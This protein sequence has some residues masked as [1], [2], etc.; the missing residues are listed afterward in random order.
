ME[1]IEL[2]FTTAPLKAVQVVESAPT[3]SVEKPSTE[4]TSEPQ[5]L[6]VS[7][8]N[9]LIRENL[10]SK[11]SLIWLRGEISNFKAHSSG[12]HYFSL[13]DSK[14]QINAIMFRAFNQRLKFRPQD[15]MEVVVR[16]KITVYEPRGNYQMF[17]ELMEPMGAGAL[18]MAFEQ[19]KKKL[20]QE[21]LFEASR[22]RALPAWPR[23][24]AVVTSPTGA[25]IR[26]ILNVL[27]RR[28]RGLR[29]TVI[30]ALVQGE[31]AT[32]SIVRAIQTAQLIPDVDVM[33]V[34][35]GGGSLEDMWAFNTEPVARAIAASRIPTISAVGHEVDF[36][37]A[38]FV[39]D[40]RAPTPS[41]A[42]ELVVK[43]A[44][45]VTDRIETFFAR[46]QNLMK[47]T[48][49]FKNQAV[50]LQTQRLIDPRRRLTDMILRLDELRSRLENAI[51]KTFSNRRMQIQIL[52]GRMGSPQDVIAA[53]THRLERAQSL[54]QVGLQKKL[55]RLQS[56]Y[57]MAVGLLDSLSPLRVVER[58]YA[59]VLKERSVVKS[60]Q[61]LAVGEQ[62]QVRLAEGEF[63][64]EVLAI[65][66][67]E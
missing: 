24:L 22:K 25:A 37:I 8:I 5:I 14:C 57:Q 46:L 44:A 3:K 30:P 62:L 65:Q 54:L 53:R 66:G 34:G 12:H 36:T 63:T 17:C 7:D 10:E 11:Y 1:Q 29:V 16:G 52:N 32:G 2:N 31:Q 20:A 9:R 13:K 4:E 51:S 18:Q 59:L 26:D 6:S 50:H 58:G 28:F 64:A 15:G 33:I 61:T 39:A 48:L 42:A 56:R 38:D 60:V 27:H 23:H 35:R 49:A 45:E 21:G 43:N 47:Q 41:A 67:A 55:Q 19:L 40:L